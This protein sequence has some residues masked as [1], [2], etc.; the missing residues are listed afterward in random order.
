M[1]CKRLKRARLVDPETEDAENVWWTGKALK[2]TERVSA[3]LLQIISTVSIQD[4][5]SDAAY[6]IQFRQEPLAAVYSAD[7]P[8]KT[9]PWRLLLHP[10]RISSGWAGVVAALDA[11][12]WSSSH[13][14][15]GGKILG[16]RVSCCA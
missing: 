10:V 11:G 9:S 14:L 12:N 4:G 1:I 6:R 8:N 15:V 13:W 16:K 5:Q 2:K 7:A 3:E